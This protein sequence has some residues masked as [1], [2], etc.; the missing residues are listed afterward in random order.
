MASKYKAVRTTVGG[1]TFDS[2]REAKRWYEAGLSAE[3]GPAKCERCGY[4]RSPSDALVLYA[5]CGVSENG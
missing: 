2:K 1:I 4:T 3:E 5:L